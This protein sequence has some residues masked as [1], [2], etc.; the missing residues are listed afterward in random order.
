MSASL[1]P[2][3]SVSPST[4]LT[5]TSA[6]TSST[7][8]SP[9]LRPSS[10][11]T[12]ASSSIS[13][14]TFP[15]S[16]LLTNK[17]SAAS[18]I[19]PVLSLRSSSLTSPS[20]PLSSAITSRSDI[21]GLSSPTQFTTV[22][23]SSSSSPLPSGSAANVQPL[24]FLIVPGPTLVKRSLRRRVLGGFVVENTNEDRQDCNNAKPYDLAFG[25]LSIDGVPVF[26]AG[27]SYKLLNAGGIPP[28]DSVITTFSVSEGTLQFSNPIL[29][30]DQAS[31][32]QDRTARV[33][34]TFASRPPNCDP[35]SLVAYTVEQCQNGQI[36]ARSSSSQDMDSSRLSATSSSLI[37][38]SSSPTNT[39]VN[40][41]HY[42]R[43]DGDAE[44]VLKPYIVIT[45]SQCLAVLFVG[46][47]PLVN[48]AFPISIFVVVNNEL[49]YSSISSIH[50][51]ECRKPHLYRNTNAVFGNCFQ[52]PFN[53]LIYIKPH[54]QLFIPHDESV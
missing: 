29:P 33:Y 38:S 44:H 6:I 37:G 53:Y 13:T 27:E 52:P 47:A 5:D 9:P 20:G 8:P 14:F 18:S 15:T 32:C 42:I 30:V 1:G 49:S 7:G 34:I 17:S 45:G 43:F 28:V 41:N 26:Y 25:Q 36:V 2:S 48:I 35:V 51:G 12:S 10:F 19:G 50:L 11:L 3:L 24:I 21:S 31:F 54:E 4:I 40:L 39:V 23:S 46:A 16:T 22:S